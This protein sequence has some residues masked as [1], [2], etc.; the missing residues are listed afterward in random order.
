[1]DIRG[2]LTQP[3]EA[4]RVGEEAQDRIGVH[5]QAGDEVHGGRLFEASA[6]SWVGAATRA[7]GKQSLVAG[8]EVVH[9]RARQTAI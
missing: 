3:G 7:R 6:P 9:R 4:A 5:A 8:R 2:L 1:M